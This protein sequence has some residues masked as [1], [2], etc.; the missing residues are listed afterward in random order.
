MKRRTIN[1]ELNEIKYE[2]IIN[3]TKFFLQYYQKK[4]PEKKSFDMLITNVVSQCPSILEMTYKFNE[5]IWP[6]DYPEFYNNLIEFKVQLSGN[7]GYLL[8]RL[9]LNKGYDQTPILLKP[10]S[11]EWDWNINK[12]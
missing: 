1:M 10:C 3:L 6:P 11:Y 12:E 7:L 9:F 8:F 4:N 2:Y 5:E